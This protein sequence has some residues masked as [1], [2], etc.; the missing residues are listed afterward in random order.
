MERRM[1]GTL[2]VGATAVGV[3]T[4]LMALASTAQTPDGYIHASFRG[5]LEVFS[6]PTA[7]V[8]AIGDGTNDTA[9]I[10]EI[11]ALLNGPLGPAAKTGVPDS[12]YR[13]AFEA[14]AAPN[15]TSTPTVSLPP[16]DSTPITAAPTRKDAA[17]LP[18]KPVVDSGGKIDCSGAVSCRTDPA[19]NVTTV[20]YP[21]GVV[22]IVQ[23]IND[24]TVVAY[25]TITEVLPAEISS[26]LPPVP[27]STPPLVAAVAPPPA[28]ATAPIDP[29]IE[30]TPDEVASAPETKS[31]SIDPGPPAPDLDLKPDLDLDLDGNGDGPKVSVAKPPKDFSPEADDSK[32][33]P[34]LTAPKVPDLGGKVKD[35]I[36]GVVDAVKGAVGKALGPG[37]S[38]P[39]AGDDSSQD[40]PSSKDSPNSRSGRSAGGNSDGS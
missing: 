22:A 15:A 40:A 19:T 3:A 7:D 37:A 1:R 11:A 4:G 16:V 17:I 9:E 23:K 8:V 10:A 14:G 34:D 6:S 31:T 30:S 18:S 2:R 5:P 32:I 33:G 21:D 35:T 20:T 26:W 36:G 13:V 25:K 28:P 24:L 27:S 12:P 38:T 29:V 39:S